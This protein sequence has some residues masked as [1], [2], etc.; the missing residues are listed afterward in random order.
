MRLRFLLLLGVALAWS[1]G[2][3]TPSAALSLGFDCITG[4]NAGDCATGEAQLRVD[5]SDPGNGK[6]E[7]TFHN[8]GPKASAITHVYWD[9]DCL[10]SFGSIVETLGVDFD[11]GAYPGNVVG[12]SGAS[13]DF[14]ATR[15][16]S[17]D[18]DTPRAHYGVNPREILIIRL[19]LNSGSVFSD[20]IQALEDG[21]LRIAVQVKGFD[22]CGEESFVNSPL[23]NIP[24]PEPG[25]FA[26]VAFG[27]LGLAGAGR[28]AR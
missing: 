11:R 1:Y 23:E 8:Q 27:M 20:A 18:A 21:S 25:T 16:L 5:V 3:A 2:H 17:A 4:N 12:W 10:L 19:K 9:D 13:P 28:R 26:L 7:F 15:G 24:V 22:S 14:K 6:V